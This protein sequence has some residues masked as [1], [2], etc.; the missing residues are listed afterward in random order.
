MTAVE[1]STPAIEAAQRRTLGV[2]SGASVLSGIAVAG[3]IPAGAL[4]AASIADSEAAA[5]LA[6]TAGVVGAALLALPLARIALTR[7]RRAALSTGYALGAVG[8]VVV[9]AAS[10]ARSLPALLIGCLLVGVASA[11]GY[12]ARYA[13]TD[14]AEDRHRAR[15]LAWVVWA[16][17]MP[18]SS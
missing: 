6:Q 8:G 2:L 7:G 5:G 15:A 11:A 10:L 13:A 12:Q 4:L 1:A 18:I 14:L 17:T 3:S 9:V 16:G